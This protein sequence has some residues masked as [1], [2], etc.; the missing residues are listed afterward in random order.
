M[1]SGKDVFLK[2]EIMFSKGNILF[3]IHHH[4]II[5]VMDIE[6]EEIIWTWG[7]QELQ[8]PH[9]PSI[10]KNGNILIFDNGTVRQYSRIIELNPKTEEIEWEYV[11][12]PPEL[13]YTETRGSVQRLPNGNT[14]ITE[15]DNNDSF[16]N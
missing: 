13:F 14:L 7:T 3:C 1:V 15:S 5:G 16:F 8:G 9:Q 6:K 10:M 4:N 11:A 12:N 2:D